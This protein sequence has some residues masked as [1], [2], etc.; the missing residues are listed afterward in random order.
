[1]S[2]RLITISNFRNLGIDKP[3]TL[4][5]NDTYEKGK[6][7]DLIILIG[8][9]NAG[10]SN[11]LSALKVIKNIKFAKSDIPLINFTNNGLPEIKYIIQS[12]NGNYY[13]TIYKYNENSSSY[14]NYD[15]NDK[16]TET[17]NNLTEEEIEK[18]GKLTPNVVIYENKDITTSDFNSTPEN[19]TSNKFLSAVFSAINISPAKIKET[20]NQYKESPNIFI[21]K[22]LQDSINQEL[23]KVSALFNN[24]YKS[25]SDPYKFIIILYDRQISFGLGRGK[26]NSL[27]PLV[28]ERQSTGFQWFFNFFFAIYNHSSINP[29]DIVIM[30]E[31]ATNLHPQGQKELRD[32]IKSFA[33]EN[34]ITFIIATHS[35][36]LINNDELDE[37]RVVKMKDSKAEIINL[38][39]AVDIDD[40]DSL[41]PI[42]DAL[43]IKQNILY[44]FDTRVVWVEGITDYNYLT[45]FKNLLSYTN[46]SFLPFKGV[47]KEDQQNI[48]IQKLASIKFPNVEILVDADK[49]GLAFKQK[50]QNTKFKDRVISVDQVSSTTKLKEIENLFSVADRQ[51]YKALD[52]ND[53]DS[54]KKAA[55]TSAMKKFCKLEDFSKETID[56]FKALFD[57]LIN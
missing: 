20:Y 34:D 1:M 28:L 22:I 3:T 18:L 32:F 36:F 37:L 29:G 44:D 4:L 26:D 45:M 40:P 57:L 30:D 47:G 41:L 53:Q 39:S 33:I 8:Q 17:I 11:V 50:C 12:D 55:T 13:S 35:P 48:I 56:N 16:P 25:T 2:K 54:F 9:N 15:R 46:I 6:S 27:T 5:L 43:T 51:K 52:D 49:A 7:G 10:K 23:E 19:L 31:P 14:Y 38:F 42:K 24:L 21:L